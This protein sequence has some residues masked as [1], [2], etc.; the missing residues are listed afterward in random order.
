M[1]VFK[2]MSADQQVLSAKELGMMF[3]YMEE[4]VWNKFCDTYEGIYDQLGGFNDFY[5][6]NPKAPL[7][8]GLE[9]PDLSEEWEKYI[10]GK[11]T[12]DSLF[13]NE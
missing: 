12:F 2:T 13:A 8:Q 10:N 4:D 5:A 1:N 7:P 6:T 3:N 11:A 9:L